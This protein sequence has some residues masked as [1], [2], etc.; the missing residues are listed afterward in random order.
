[1]RAFSALPPSTQSNIMKMLCLLILSIIVEGAN[2]AFLIPIFRS[3]LTHNLSDL[4]YYSTIFI[5]ITLL[6]LFILYY[7]LRAGYLSGVSLALGLIQRLLYHLP[8]IQLDQNLYQLHPQNL[9]RHSVLEAMGIPAHLLEPILRTVLTPI[10]FASVMIGF[11]P[12]LGFS[13]LIIFILLAIFMRYFTNSNQIFDLQKQQSD[14]IVAKELQLFANQQP[15]LRASQLTQQSD[16]RLHDALIQQNHSS[17]SLMRRKFWLDISY[18]SILQVILL[19]IL[20]TS[21]ISAAHQVLDSGL[22]LALLIVLFHF[23]EP[24]SQLLQLNQSLQSSW[25]SLM[26]VIQVLELPL[27]RTKTSVQLPN[28]YDIQLSNISYQTENNRTVIRNFSHLFKAQTT[29]VIIGTSG[30]GKSTLL[31]LIAGIIQP[32]EG[33][34]AIDNIDVRNFDYLQLSQLR[35]LFSQDVALFKESIAWN[36][37]IGNLD[38][39]DQDIDET[40]QNIGLQQDLKNMPNGKHTNIGPNGN[41][42][43]GGQRARVALAR[44]FLNPAPILLL[45]E[46]TAN[47]DS[48]RSQLIIKTLKE[49]HGKRTIIIVTHDQQ[50]MKIADHQIKMV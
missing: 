15:L 41:Q 9:V 32:T 33:N 14:N 17:V 23:I 10:I 38:A 4:I 42:L 29:T 19:I 35:A 27:T 39:T 16:Q 47:L 12:I 50:L 7:A 44:T 22:L 37:Q 36:I 45:D 49:M 20:I 13:L 8:F 6:Q 21:M 3:A 30:V 43:S 24:Y 31:K 48:E 25:Q 2:F 1:M 34:I 28:H 46:P 18:I 11:S 26:R 5:S 40:L